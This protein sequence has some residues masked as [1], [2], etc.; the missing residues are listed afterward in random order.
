MYK[1][2]AVKLCDIHGK[3]YGMR[4]KLDVDLIANW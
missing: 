2:K 1:L 3:H 4:I